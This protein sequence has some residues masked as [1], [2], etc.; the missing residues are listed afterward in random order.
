MAYSAKFSSKFYGPFRDAAFSA[1]SFGD[2]KSYQM[3]YSNG[4][5]AIREVLL[6]IN[7]GADII[8]VKPALAYLDLV[9]KIKMKFGFPTAVYNVS[10]EYSMIKAAAEKGWIDEKGVVLESL[11]SMKRAGADMILTYFAKEV[12]GWLKESEREFKKVI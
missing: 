6:D 7:E 2:R 8:M 5:E 4:N 9:Y 12:A 3:D 11:L 1:P 10:G